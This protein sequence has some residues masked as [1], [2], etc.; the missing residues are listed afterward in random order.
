[1]E[2]TEGLGCSLGIVVPIRQA[3]KPEK[4]IRDAAAYPIISVGGF[5]Y[6]ATN[7]GPRA[8]ETCWNNGHFKRA[9]G[10]TPGLLFSKEDLS[11]NKPSNQARYG[12]CP[13]P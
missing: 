1:M 11:S 5:T 13:V 2:V 4:S 10:I 7:F 3:H 6:P 8:I 9:R 12:L